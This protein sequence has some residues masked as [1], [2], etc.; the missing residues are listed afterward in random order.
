MTRRIAITR[1]VSPAIERC[2]LTHLPRTEIDFERA[3][4]QHRQYET[5][6][7]ELGC[8][9]RSLPAD[10]EL[11]DSVF[12]EDC[13]LV[14]EDV[15]LI[16]RP[17]AASRRP[18]TMAVAEALE[19]YR[20]LWHLRAPATLDGGD[21]LQLGQAIYLG[22]SS[23]SDRLALDQLH[24]LLA[25]KGYTLRC[26]DVKRCLHL[27][28]AVTRVAAETLLVNPEWVDP[29]AFPGLRCIEV[30]PAEPHAANA[31]LVGETVVFPGAFPRTRERLE[32]AGLAV[33]DVEVSELAKAEGGVTCCSLIFA[34]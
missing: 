33:R 34:A 32:G 21:V 15:A 24:E 19:P 1:R 26:L 14:L 17:G 20:P 13:A 27:K 4:E 25:P 11:P 23:R 29:A 7:G 2:E 3:Q 28:S 31:L 5:L 9:L 10:P 8:D 16:T 12:V 22:I 18:E 6:L 30:D